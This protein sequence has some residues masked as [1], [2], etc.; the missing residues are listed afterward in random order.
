ML[1]IVGAVTDFAVGGLNYTMHDVH[2]YSN[3]NDEGQLRKLD[4]QFDA[5]HR[6]FM[7]AMRWPTPWKKQ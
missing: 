4:E 6:K 5:L 2:Y 3:Q 1:K 7:T